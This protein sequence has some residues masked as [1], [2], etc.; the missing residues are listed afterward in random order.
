MVLGPARSFKV[1][2]PLLL[3]LIM[4]NRA[5]RKRKDY[6]VWIAGGLFAV[7]AAAF[8]YWGVPLIV[9]GTGA[10]AHLR[11]RAARLRGAPPGKAAAEVA[12]IV[13]GFLDLSKEANQVEVRIDEAGADRIALTLIVPWSMS[14]PKVHRRRSGAAARLT[15]ALLKSAGAEQVGVSVNVRRKCTSPGASDPAGRTLY[16]PRSGVF[17]WRGA[18]GL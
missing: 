6:P 15:V 9:S 16:R 10:Q 2:T 1:L 12:R 5:P 4:A 8:F 13:K 11:A 18:G 7:L 14:A 17:E 3:R